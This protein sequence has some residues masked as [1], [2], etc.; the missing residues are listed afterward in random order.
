MVK[1]LPY[2][3]TQPLRLDTHHDDIHH[4]D[5]QNKVLICNTLNDTKH[6]QHSAYYVITLEIHLNNRIVANMVVTKYIILQLQV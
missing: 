3:G 2:A 5:T 1:S 6:K 4:N